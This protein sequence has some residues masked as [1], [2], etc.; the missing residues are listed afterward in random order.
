MVKPKLIRD[1]AVRTQASSVFSSASRVLI[2]AKWL[3]AVVRTVNGLPE[4]SFSSVIITPRRSGVIDQ[5]Y[6]LA[7]IMFPAAHNF[8]GA[9][10]GIFARHPD[11]AAGVT[12]N[13]EIAV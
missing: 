12:K 1:A 13:F 10:G 6:H 3:S 5:N 9:A 11:A 7:S 4:L 8:G 2:H